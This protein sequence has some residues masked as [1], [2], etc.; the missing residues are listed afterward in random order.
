MF[1]MYELNERQKKEG[2]LNV[3]A[4]KMKLHSD[5]SHTECAVGE[6]NQNRKISLQLTIILNAEAD[7][8]LHLLCKTYRLRYR[9]FIA[10]RIPG[11]NILQIYITLLTTKINLFYLTGIR[12]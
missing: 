7:R 9:W 1:F 12:V 5:K 2:S 4:E 11:I 3:Q 10:I 6:S 8:K